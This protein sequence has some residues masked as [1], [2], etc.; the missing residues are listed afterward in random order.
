MAF[1]T[2][3][4][5]GLLDF[6]NAELILRLNFMPRQAHEPLDRATCPIAEALP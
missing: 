4:I 6:C 1:Q 5:R 3:K 2:W